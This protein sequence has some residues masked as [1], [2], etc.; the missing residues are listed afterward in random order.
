MFST[1]K[2]AFTLVELIVV[3]TILA[4]LWTIAFI[5]LQWYSREARNSSR[6]SDIASIRKVF[7]LYQLKK[8]TYPDTTNWLNIVYSWWVVWTQWIF[9]DDTFK[10]VWKID[11]IPLDPLTNM[12]Y[13][14][15]LTSTKKQYQLAW[16]IEEQSL[17]QNYYLNDTFAEDED[18][19]LTAYVRWNYNEKLLKSVDWNS[20]K[21]LSLPS[22]IS[23]N[24]SSE[25]E[26]ITILSNYELVYSGYANLP[27]V[28]K[29][30]WFKLNWG[31][32][33]KPN[34]LLVYNDEENCNLLYNSEDASSR[35]ELVRNLKESYSWTII[36]SEP[37]I[38]E[39]VNLDTEN[40]VVIE[41][42]AWNLVNNNLAWNIVTTNANSYPD[43][44][45]DITWWTQLK[46]WNWSSWDIT[47]NSCDID[48]YKNPADET[49]I[50][51]WNGYYSLDN[52][53]ER[54]WCTNLPT[55]W[56]SYTSSWNWWNN[57]SY[58]CKS[59]YSWLDCSTVLPRYTLP[60]EWDTFVDNVNGLEW[61]KINWKYSWDEIVVQRDAKYK[62]DNNYNPPL[63]RTW[64]RLPTLEELRTISSPWDITG[65]WMS[66]ISS[67]YWT[68]TQG[69][70][71]SYR[72][73]VRRNNWH[74]TDK[75]TSNKWYFRCVRSL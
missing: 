34:K 68:S 22:I 35:V 26:L 2:N 53:I 45:I 55:N 65:S 41:K 67:Y 44:I 60:S 62:C 18:K 39:L 57:C 23:S 48:F 24:W 3:I 33:F 58:D 38:N 56:N 15:S 42:F 29:T 5:S 66:W 14:Y 73:V 40:T 50:A 8:W 4:I 72:N 17:S 59:L 46:T 28:Y 61:S 47:L 49:C 31:F 64:R 71:G 30:S 32:D 27:S 36:E 19:T 37:I 1:K 74:E 10:D 75:P 9:W 20:C 11:Q 52:S 7:E 43:E 69:Y 21:I 12:P 6:I 70:N 25:N 16:I 13:T 63:P 51:V 54:L